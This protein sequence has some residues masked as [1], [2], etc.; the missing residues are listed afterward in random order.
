MKMW[1]GHDVEADA[2]VDAGVDGSVDVAADARRYP[3]HCLS[4]TLGVVRTASSGAPLGMPS[5]QTGGEEEQ[6]KWGTLGDHVHGH[7]K[8][9]VNA[10][11]AKHHVMSCD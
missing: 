9:K 4:G 10:Q 5:H 7:Q 1:H 2:D 11:T 8:V 3:A 6:T